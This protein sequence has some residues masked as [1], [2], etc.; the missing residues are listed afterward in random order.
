MLRTVSGATFSW[1]VL[2]HVLPKGFRRARNHGFL[3]PN[4]QR[5]IA[6]LRLLV[7]KQPVRSNAQSTQSTQSAATLSP[8]P[9][10]QLL[11]R[12]C[13]AAMVIVRRR[14]LPA[15]TEPPRGEQEGTSLSR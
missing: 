11:R 9:R 2:Q 4:S 6:L 15:I 3:R 13:G 5:L 8:R 1:L 14:I 12:C 7:F 10:P